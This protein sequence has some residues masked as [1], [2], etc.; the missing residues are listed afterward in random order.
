MNDEKNDNRPIAE[1]TETS[2]SEPMKSHPIATGIGAAGGGI[3]GAAIGKAVAGRLGATVGGVAGAI[4]G[5]MAG[6]ALAEF[7]E[8][9]NENLGLGLGA[10]TREVE[11]PQHYSWEELQALSKPQ[12]EPH[13]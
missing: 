3:A 5:S 8:E 9:T 12:R 1:S 10:D 13:S 6:E 7:A 4:A 2:T 11:L